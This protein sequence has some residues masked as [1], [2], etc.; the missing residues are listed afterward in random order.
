MAL[1]STTQWSSWARGSPAIESYVRLCFKRLTSTLPT[2]VTAPCLTMQWS[3]WGPSRRIRTLVSAYRG[4]WRL[5]A[6]LDRCCYKTNPLSTLPRQP[7]STAQYRGSFACWP[8]S[9]MCAHVMNQSDKSRTEIRGIPRPP[10]NCYFETHLPCVSSDLAS[11]SVSN[12]LYNLLPLTNQ[13]TLTLYSNT[14]MGPYKTTRLAAK[15]CGK[16]SLPRSRHHE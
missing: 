1:G 2:G 11:C 16:A 10:Q 6:L 3:R 5:H 4:A 8:I 9:Y 13:I 15:S 12:P 14:P 7:P